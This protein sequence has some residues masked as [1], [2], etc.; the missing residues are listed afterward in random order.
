M[1]PGSVGSPPPMKPGQQQPN[2]AAG[3]LSYAIHW[4][5][6]S[7][8]IKSFACS[9]AHGHTEHQSAGTAARSAAGI[10]IRHARRATLRRQHGKHGF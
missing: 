5:L 1:L 7:L 2:A 10:A 8:L 3:K 9:F 6:D 4:T